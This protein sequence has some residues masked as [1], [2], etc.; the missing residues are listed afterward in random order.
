MRKIYLLFTI[1][2]MIALAGCAKQSQQTVDIKEEPNIVNSE[3]ISQV[4]TEQ[5]VAGELEEEETVVEEPVDIEN[6]ME[7]NSSINVVCWGTSLVYGTGGNGVI[8]PDVLKRISGARVLNYGGYAENTNEI[9]ARSGANALSLTSEIIIPADESPVEVSFE[10]E[11]GEIDKLLVHTDAG[12]N[13][14]RIEGVSGKLSREEEDGNVRFYFTREE[15]GEETVV[16]EGATIV[17]RAAI[18]KREDDIS[19]IWTAGNDTIVGTEDILVVIEKIDKMIEFSGS[20]K[21]IVISAVN[22]KDGVPVINEVNEMFEEHYG[23]HFFNLRKYLMED[24]FSDINIPPDE[25]DLED[26]SEDLIPSFFRA[27]EEHGNSLYY[28]LAGQQLYKKCQELNY[29]K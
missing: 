14:V 8:M 6:I 10:S 18:E 13:P 23:E 20:D 12:L 25:D 1:I 11:F 3:E 9:A 29:L 7:A 26:I 21:Y 4:V 28:L 16:S 17:P 2:T 22:I 27:D 5:E 15:P 24:A 19:V